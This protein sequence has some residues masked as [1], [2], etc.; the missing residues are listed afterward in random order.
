MKRSREELGRLHKEKCKEL[1]RVRAQMAEDLG[2]DLQ[3]TECTYEGYCSGTCPKC[4]S[5]ELRLNAALIKRQMEQAGAKRKVA[6]AGLTTVAALS[7]T[8]CDIIKGYDM[9]G[10]IQPPVSQETLTGDV[11]TVTDYAGGLAE[12]EPQSTESAALKEASSIF[13]S[14]SILV[15]IINLFI[16]NIIITLIRNK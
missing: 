3:Q 6:A 15:S 8:G 16:S 1:K 14:I 10:G 13:F 4:R 2:I 12:C 7:L 11:A 9:D 5:E